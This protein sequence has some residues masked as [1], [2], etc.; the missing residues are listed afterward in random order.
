METIYG[1]SKHYGITEEELIAANPSIA[2]G[3]KTGSGA[4]YPQSGNH[5]TSTSS[6][7]DVA[8][9]DNYIR[10]EEPATQPNKSPKPKPPSWLKKREPSKR[11]HLN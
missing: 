10:D 2:H 8:E 7:A 9:A 6:E 1:I 3:L 4:Q 5:V 11:Q